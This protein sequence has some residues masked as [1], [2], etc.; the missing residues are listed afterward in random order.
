[1][2][3][4]F[5]YAAE[6]PLK[7]EFFGRATT[8][9][10]VEVGA[11]DPERWSQTFHLENLGWSGILVEPQ[12]DLAEALQR[13]RK[14]KVFC[15]AC[16]SPENAGKRMTL[17]IAGGLS[18]L[19]PKLRVAGVRPEGTIEVPLETLDEIL[20]A[21][22][23]PSPIDFLAVDVEG[24][25]IEVLRGLDFARFRPRLVLVEDHVLNMRLHRF[26]RSRGYAWVRRTDINSWYVPADAAW[27]LGWQGRWQFLR[28]YYLAMPFRRMREVLRRMRAHIAMKAPF[29]GDEP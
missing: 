21:A 10:F 25:E 8:G 18:S 6:T 1:M 11:N 7:E 23:A 2:N 20:T 17:H 29:P 4:F 14:A 9:Y 24:H 27:P 13:R 12:P 5:P 28:K 15:V 3:A 22:D 26:M 19:D 16:S